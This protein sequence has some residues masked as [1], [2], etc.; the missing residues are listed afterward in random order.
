MVHVLHIS[1]ID[2]SDSPSALSSYCSLPC[3][4][5]NNDSDQSLNKRRVGSK[6]SAPALIQ[7]PVPSPCDLTDVFAFTTGFRR[8]S[9]IHY[10]KKVTAQHDCPIALLNLCAALAS[11]V[12]DSKPL[13]AEAVNR[14]NAD[15]GSAR[16]GALDLPVPTAPAKLAD[17]LS[18]DQFTVSLIVGHTAAVTS[19][20]V[21]GSSSPVPV[22][23]CIDPGTMGNLTLMSEDSQGTLVAPCDYHSNIAFNKAG[24]YANTSNNSPMELSFINQN[25][26]YTPDIDV[27]YVHVHF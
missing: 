1:A 22:G 2:R 19:I 20:H 25:G 5:Y 15:L 27:S 7:A 12:I 10:S 13:P 14:L 21:E 3:N 6:S 16:G 23:G 8:I 24:V 9:R 11:V 4:K 26:I 18:P 17:V